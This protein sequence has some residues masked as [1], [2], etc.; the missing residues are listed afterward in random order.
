MKYVI[1]SDIQGNYRSLERFFKKLSNSPDLDETTQLI[2]LGDIVDKG[3][4]FDDNLCIER[5]RKSKSI[6][7]R[8]N[9]E[10]RVLRNTSESLKKI[11]SRNLLSFSVRH[12]CVC[13]GVSF[14]VGHS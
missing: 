14:S 7:V 1:Y 5:I 11:A 10:D 4:S 6:A 13:G 3:D 2:C 8:G 9:H 12:L